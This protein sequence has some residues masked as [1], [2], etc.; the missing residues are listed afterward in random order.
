MSYA[1]FI[2]W[3]VFY[4][5]WHCVVSLIRSFFKATIFGIFLL[6]NRFTE[7]GNSLNTFKTHKCILLRSHFKLKRRKKKKI[8]WPFSVR[9]KRFMYSLSSSLL[10]EEKKKKNNR[11]S[12][13]IMTKLNWILIEYPFSVNEKD[14]DYGHYRL[15]Y[16]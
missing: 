13:L 1:T 14:D 10:F 7:I 11:K 6:W 5:L 2:M 15:R 8:R 3:E 4:N 16:Q 12:L 9:P